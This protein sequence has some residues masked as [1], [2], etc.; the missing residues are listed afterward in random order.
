[1]PALKKVAAVD[2]YS[3]FKTACASEISAQCE[4]VSSLDV[5]AKV[6]TVVP[7]AMDRP[8]SRPMGGDRHHAGRGDGGFRAGGHPFRRMRH[9]SDA[10]GP[11]SQ[12]PTAGDRVTELNAYV[13]LHGLLVLR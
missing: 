13:P 11:E 1:M 10:E 3:S 9:P 5:L 7:P 12:R 8:Q 2:A 4:D 6:S